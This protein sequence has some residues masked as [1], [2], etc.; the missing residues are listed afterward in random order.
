MDW[1]ILPYQRY[2][3]FS[4]RSQRKEYW[5]FQL[6][7]VLVI[8]VCA[9]IMLAG[10]PWGQTEDPAAKPGPLFWL[11]LALIVLYLLGSA[12]PHIA[13]TVRRFHDQDQSGWFYLLNFIPYIGGIVVFVF[14]C[15]EGTRGPNRY[16]PDPKDPHAAD[17][18][19]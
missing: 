4:G 5:M 7:Y 18:F 16:G 6:F 11:G 8:L 9:A 3:D 12:I 19:F 10:V 1:M 15:I 17:V 13:V 14:M 2:F